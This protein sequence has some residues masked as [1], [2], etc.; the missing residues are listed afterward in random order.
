MVLMEESYYHV[1]G[2]TG[3]VY[4]RWTDG[5]AGERQ[6][7]AGVSVAGWELRRVRPVI[8]LDVWSQTLDGAGA[9]AAVGGRIAG[10]PSQRAEVEVSVGAKSAG[11]SRVTLYTAGPTSTRGSR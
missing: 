4:V 9:R 11:Y 10:W 8:D 7:G 1:R 5:F 3:G 6:A 2:R